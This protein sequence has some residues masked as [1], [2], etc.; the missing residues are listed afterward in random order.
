MLAF[1]TT[2]P[3]FLFLSIGCSIGAKKVKAECTLFREYCKAGNGEG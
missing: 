2:I 1:S 3:S